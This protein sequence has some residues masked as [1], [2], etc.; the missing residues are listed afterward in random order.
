MIEL[1]AMESDDPQFIEMVSQILSGAINCYKPNDVYVVHL[2]NWFDHKWNAFAAVIDLQCGMWAADKLTKPPF[3]P[4]RVIS[5]SY[6]RLDELTK[7]IYINDEAPLLHT[8]RSSY[9]NFHDRLRDLTHAGLFLWYSGNTKPNGR[10]SLMVYNIG[11]EV[12]IYW[13]VSFLKKKEW[14]VNKAKNI[15][16]K[17]IDGLLKNSELQLTA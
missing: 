3:N 4:N 6:F 13:Y 9:W 10:G 14:Q 11:K 17:A 16:K 12:S 7:S 5:Q 1:K 2:D 8:R 15:S